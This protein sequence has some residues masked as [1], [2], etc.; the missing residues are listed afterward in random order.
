M[1]IGIDLGTTFSAAAY[2]EN[3][4][5]N[6]ILNKEN[7]K[8]TA[9]V[10]CIT[11]GVAIVG[12]NAKK[13]VN[14]KDAFI[15]E[16][17]KDYMGTDKTYTDNQGKTYTPEQISAL[18]LKK[19][20]NDAEE[21]LGCIVDK[22]VITVPAYFNDAQRTATK[23]AGALAGLKVESI[24][25]E[26]TAAAICAARESDLANGKVLVYDLGGG[27]FDVSIVDISGDNTN[28]IA[29]GGIRKLGGH[30]FDEKI[31]DYV[32]K[33]LLESQGVNITLPDRKS[34]LQEITRK[35]EQC[36]INLSYE[37]QS[38]VELFVNGS[39]VIVD[40]TRSQFEQM[41]RGYYRR[42]ESVMEMVLD[43]AGLGWDEIDA[44]LLVGGSS[45][46]P[47]IKEKIEGLTG[48]K[49]SEAVNPDEA[50]S[51]GAAIYAS[52]L[53][54]KDTV[55]DVCSHSLGIV[56]LNKNTREK[57]N[58][59]ILS[60]N[61]ALPAK[62]SKTYYIPAD[63]IPKISLEV[64]E[65]EE[66][67]LEYDT[68]LAEIDIELPEGI[69]KNTAVTVEMELDKEQLLHVF[70][71]IQSNPEVYKEVVIKR[72]KDISEEEF[73]NQCTLLEEMDVTGELQK[74]AVVVE[75]RDIGGEPKK[76]VSASSLGASAA[77][78]GVAGVT[79]RILPDDLIDKAFDKLIGMESVKS[80]LQSFYN[81]VKMEKLRAEQL[82]FTETEKK[83][84]NF[85]IY[86][87]PGTGKTT[88]AR[89]IANVLYT[90][91]ILPKD[92]FIEVDRAELV[93]GYVGQTATKVKEVIEKAKGGV[94]FIDEAYSLYNK[95]NANDFGIEAIN[96]LLKDMEDNRGEYSVIL[97]GYNKQMN[98]M[99]NNVN[100]G[101]RSRFTYHINIP[102]YT[103]DELIEIAKVI[104]S[105][106]HYSITEDGFDAIRK[107]VVKERIDDTF[108]NARFIRK[109]IDE[110]VE[111]L[112]NRLAK[113]GNITRDDMLYLTG[114]DILPSGKD[115][116]SIEEYIEELNKLVGLNDAKM[117]VQQM[118]DSII[119]AKEVEKR[120]L[121][122]GT[123]LGSL[124]MCF[125]GNPGTGKTTVARLI[126]KIF[127]QLGILKR[128]DIFV[129]VS[130]ADLVGQY[131]GHTA[132]KTQEIVRSALG[133]ILFID[134]AYSLIK[135]AD[136]SFGSEAID[137]LIAEMENHR[138]SL[139]VILAGYSDEMNTFIARNPG[140]RS[141][142]TRDL[143]FEDYTP[144]EMVRIFRHLVSKNGLTIDES[145]DSVV[146]NKLA[147]LSMRADFGNARG[148]R[149]YY[150]GV[151]RNKN[152]RIT[153]SIKNGVELSDELLMEIL[154]EDL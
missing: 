26:P 2:V 110:A 8:L 133:G 61:T 37:M 100:P 76:P 66:E 132:V 115:V 95:E 65:G 111:N 77:S 29:T 113:K 154:E 30:F 16:T 47:Y 94:L 74:E 143:M 140:M 5:P 40:I 10:V 89:I 86:G 97:A 141:R 35:A 36:K 75:I 120:G 107:R 53:G 9:S 14:S 150:E 118:V 104:A 28:V 17:V 117:A 60:R 21:R 51:M 48:Q 7:S 129:E 59:I 52:E 39:E 12:E 42:T 88:V 25:N 153:S 84:Y 144:N 43:D 56:T 33:I 146:Y 80:E 78:S 92:T 108:G 38:C 112:A 23:N 67:E 116:K 57:Y 124:H 106:S 20:K 119:V 45:K 105:K 109:V 63:N 147:E 99:L 103:D 114:E 24:I 4:K 79:N 13:Q 34:L 138:D 96:T 71:R 134:E 73:A 149:N 6:I 68:I 123:E 41:I 142:I 82:G 127:A 32:G 93:V 49:P 64:T 15:V 136:D 81:L 70:A 11:D 90:L 148:V 31:V 44:V 145:L 3:N 151:I 50:V 91:G 98:E 135:D 128:D 131:V 130:R 137:T 85:V 1:I 122:I 54:I 22:A 46:I 27:T 102:D 58:S 126:G 139:V 18:I 152:S 69:E 87:N 121:N 62:T 72:S 101:F 19:I 55:L 125:M 83:A